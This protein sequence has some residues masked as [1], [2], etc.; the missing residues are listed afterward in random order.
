M[1]PRPDGGE[2]A[3][4]AVSMG[5]PAGI[6]LEITL[7]AW[8][9]RADAHLAPFVLFAD[10][11]TVEERTRA[12]GLKVPVAV[13]ATLDAVPHAFPMALP[14]RPVPLAA[15]SQ[16]GTPDPANA[17][18]VIASIE[19]ATEAV[20]AGTAA[21]LVTNPIAKHILGA[22][23]FPHPGHTE[24]LAALAHRHYGGSYHP[25]MM[26][27]AGDF[28]VV[29]LTVHCALAKV[30]P[31]ITRSLIIDTARIVDAS[32]KRDFSLA[33]PRIAITGLNPHA[34]EAGTMG[35]EEIDVIAPA[36]AELRAGGLDVSGPHPADTLFHTAARR[37]YDAAI[38]MYHDQALIPFK[39]I[40]FEDGV[41]V[42]L[43]L[44]FVRTSPDHGT[45][46]DIAAAGRASPTS[47]IESLKLASNIAA[48]RAAAAP[49]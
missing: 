8:S 30:A 34:G 46:F 17:A 32:L 31:A 40:A 38:A 29:P 35:S 39:T 14:V 15:R 6:G 20:A 45:A 42:T 12:L 21:A 5:D 25:V 9:A 43:G 13:V 44:P 36:I 16:A 22:A 23:G 19:Q 48:A 49:S 2:L 33:S 47:F 26:L 3:P 10:P 24:F 28:R 37:T 11:A 7:K 4:L 18:A 27:A 1:R 41:N